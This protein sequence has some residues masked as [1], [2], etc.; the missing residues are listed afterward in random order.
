[1]IDHYHI[2]LSLNKKLLSPGFKVY[3][4]HHGN[5]SHTRK[6]EAIDDGLTSECHFH[7]VVESHSDAR[8]AVS[9]C[10]GVVGR[11]SL[12]SISR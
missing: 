8:A 10:A 7:G 2:K 9:L 1:M 11:F 4:R 6:E 12:L 3:H 5:K